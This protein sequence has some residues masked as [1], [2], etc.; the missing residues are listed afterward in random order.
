MGSLAENPDI[1]MHYAGQKLASFRANIIGIGL[2]QGVCSDCAFVEE[3]P[4]QEQIEFMK[5]INPNQPS[6]ATGHIS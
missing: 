2:K 3:Q 5:R 1:F 6:M 4:T